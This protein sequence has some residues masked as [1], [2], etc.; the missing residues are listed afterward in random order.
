MSGRPQPKIEDVKFPLRSGI[1]L[2]KKARRMLWD[3][4]KTPEQ[5]DRYIYISQALEEFE[6]ADQNSALLEESIKKLERRQK[7]HGNTTD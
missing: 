6:R 3:D 1:D 2:L 7:Q 5:K 4:M